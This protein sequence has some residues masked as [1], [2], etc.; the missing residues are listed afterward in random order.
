MTRRDYQII[1]NAVRQMFSLGE[2]QLYVADMLAV[3]LAKDNPKFD[4][5][6]FLEACGVEEK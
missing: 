3:V 6:K 2:N 4:R 1:A 5:S